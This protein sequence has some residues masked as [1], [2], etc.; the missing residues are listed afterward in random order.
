MVLLLV[1]NIFSMI[2]LLGDVFYSMIMLI[3]QSP[4][5]NLVLI[6]KVTS[7]IL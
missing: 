5:V 4:T 1:K 7:M 6:E 3:G 2:L